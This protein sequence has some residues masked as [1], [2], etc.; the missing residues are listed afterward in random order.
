MESVKRSALNF[1]SRPASRVNKNSCFNSATK[2]KH[3]IEV[4]QGN[5]IDNHSTFPVSAKMIRLVF[6]IAPAFIVAAASEGIVKRQDEVHGFQE[7][8][9]LL[10]KRTGFGENVFIRGGVGN[11]KDCAPDEDPKDDPCAIPITH[12]ELDMSSE[13]PLRDEWAESDLYLTWGESKDE[14]DS[15]LDGTPAQWTTSD[16]SNDYFHP[17]NKYGDH[18]WMVHFEMNCSALENGFFDFKGYLSGQWESDI[19]QSDCDGDAAETPSYTSNNHIGRCG[20]INVFKWGS[21]DCK[22]V[23]FD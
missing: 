5:K 9:V 4:K 13:T 8:V 22:M 16:Q 7:T 11:G 14:K 20:Y 15:V 18:Y 6:F 19:S 2:K 10:K 1:E 23:S 12:L 3:D 17:L 21:S